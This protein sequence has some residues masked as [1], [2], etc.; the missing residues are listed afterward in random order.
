MDQK[1]NFFIDI[2]KDYSSENKK[3]RI[4]RL[5]EFDFSDFPGF[6]GNFL[7]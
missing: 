1:K 3:P 5:W 6:P 2:Y 4:S 7:I